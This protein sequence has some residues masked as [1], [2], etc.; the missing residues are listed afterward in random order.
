MMDGQKQ[1]QSYMMM[2][3]SVKLTKH[4]TIHKL[5]FSIEHAL[6]IRCLNVVYKSTLK[7]TLKYTKT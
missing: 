7:D 6:F 5:E 1:T 3:M 4:R 2:A